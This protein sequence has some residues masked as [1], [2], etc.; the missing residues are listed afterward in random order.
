[1]QDRQSFAGSERA[2]EEDFFYKRDRELLDKARRQAEVEAERRYLGEITGIA[3]EEIVR[4]LQQLGYNRE[5]V[6]LLNLSPLIDVAWSDGSLTEQERKFIF[7]AARQESVEEGGP[8][9]RQLAAWLKNR[10][11]DQ[12]F[13]STLRALRAKFRALPREER[14]R[15]ERDLVAQC[16][17]VASASGGVLG[18]GSKLSEAERRVIARITAELKYEA[19]RAGPGQ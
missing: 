17:R 2:K 14:E 12:F 8:G 4:E 11:A 7:E 13:H 6:V 15:K 10:P 5:T 1:M 3:D 19:D 16:T 9:W 18:L